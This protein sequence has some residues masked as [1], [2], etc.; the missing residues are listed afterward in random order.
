V[1]QLIQKLFLQLLVL[2]TLLLLNPTISSADIGKITEQTGPTE[3]KRD[4]F[5][6]PSSIQSRVEMRDTITT[7]NGKAGITFQ[8]DTKVQITE[9]SRLIIDSF[10]YDDSKK[11][12]KLGMKMALGTI[13][14]ASGQIAKNN[15]QQVIIETPTATIGVRGTDFSGTVDE[16]GRS[17]IILLPSCPSSWRNI[18]RDCIVG[19]ISVTT[20][21]GTIWLTRAF[22]TVSIQTSMNTPKSS[23]MNLN[24]DQINNLI[25]VTPPKAVKVEVTTTTTTFNFL[26]EDLLGKDL[27]KYDELNKNYLSEYNKLDRNFLDTDFLYNLLDVAS[28]QLLTNELA[29]FN[30]LLPKYTPVSGLKY[31]IENDFVTLYR[32]TY[33]AYAQVTTPITQTMSMNLSQEGIEIKQVVNFAGNTSINIRQSN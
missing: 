25:I 20:D 16:I 12:G 6:I 27:L 7:A 2:V 13:K 4:T 22:E 19:S 28:S 5:I 14:Y 15:P 23:I 3:I 24:L 26:D 10:V 33:N 9:H 18:E 11:T 31:Y 17:T 1:V 32:E 21:M 30:S 8:D 29:D